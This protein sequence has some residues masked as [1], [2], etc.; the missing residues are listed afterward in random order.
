[1]TMSLCLPHALSLKTGCTT[2]LSRIPDA[3]PVLPDP[4]RALSEIVVPMPSTPK[5][6]ASQRCVSAL[7]SEALRAAYTPTDL[8]SSSAT[9]H[10]LT[11]FTV[12]GGFAEFG[13]VCLKLW[14][15]ERIQSRSMKAALACVFS[16]AHLY[17]ANLR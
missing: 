16:G 15:R 5:K 3:A 2:R 17:I 10:T 9:D 12:P 11:I 8:V 4:I 7:N 13:W 14:A 6:S 1:M